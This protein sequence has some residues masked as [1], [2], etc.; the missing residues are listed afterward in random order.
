[1]QVENTCLFY[2]MR[3][4]SQMGLLIDPEAYNHQLWPIFQ[5]L[6]S[7][8]QEHG[9]IISLLMST[10][11]PSLRYLLLEYPVIFDTML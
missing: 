8:P 11:Y 9:L 3:L 7:V 5:A 2:I 1:M 4:I 10:S 6:E